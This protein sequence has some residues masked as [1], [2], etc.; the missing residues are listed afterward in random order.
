MLIDCGEGTQ[1]QAMQC[2]ALR[3]SS[4]STIL[5]THLHGDHCFGIFGMLCSMSMGSSRYNPVTVVGPKGTQELVET[6]LRL[7]A[8]QL[9]YPLRFVELPVEPQA[10][11]DLGA[12][13]G[14]LSVLALPLKHV[15]GVPTYGYRITET[16]QRG[17]VDVTR[18]RDLGIDPATQG[19]L[20]GKL[21]SG[22]SVTVGSS[23]VK[24]EDVVG[25]ERPGRVFAVLQDTCDTSEAE[26][27]LDDV[28][29]LVHESTYDSSLQEKAVE[30]G[31]S[32]ATMAGE[33]ASRVNAKNLVLTH[34][35]PRYAPSKDNPDGLV[36]NDLVREAQK[37][38]PGNVWAAKDFMCFEVGSRGSPISS[39]MAFNNIKE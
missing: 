2:T 39:L 29:M 21:T 33:C 24:P 5:L 26:K 25:P 17:K 18:A 15:D 4:I 6:V 37:C 11:V 8:S 35:S 12:L 23:L 7:S 31:H 27:E 30:Y 16:P 32:T 1:Q 36:V 9:S 14:G 19:P 13:I 34:F 22:K 38:F 10:P 28:F 20:I 3:M